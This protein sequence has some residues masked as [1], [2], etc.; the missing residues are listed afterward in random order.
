MTLKDLGFPRKILFGA[1]A[2]NDEVVE[3]AG[4]VGGVS[5]SQLLYYSPLEMSAEDSS[6]PTAQVED[7]DPPS[8]LE[9]LSDF[10]SQKVSCLPPLH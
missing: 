10:D 5:S 3:E 1:V 9:I 2:V 8:S 7:R 4:D 6:P